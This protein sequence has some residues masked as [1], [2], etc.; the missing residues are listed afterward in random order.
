MGKGRGGGNGVIE[1]DHETENATALYYNRE[2]WKQRSN[3][4]GCYRLQF[5]YTY[6]EINFVALK[7][8]EFNQE[9]YVRITRL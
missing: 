3:W 5:N 7:P 8:P 9:L 6:I 4:D 2:E 1:F